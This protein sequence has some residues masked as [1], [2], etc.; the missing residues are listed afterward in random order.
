MPHQNLLLSPEKVSLTVSLACWNMLWPLSPAFCESDFVL[1]GCID[2]R[3]LS[4][5]PDALSLV[6]CES[7]FM[8]SGCMALEALSVKDSRLCRP[9]HG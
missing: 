6:F 3:A 1:P 5:P 8:L 9:R 2:P 4:M 7:D